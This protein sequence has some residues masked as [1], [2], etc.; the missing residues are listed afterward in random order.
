[1][2]ELELLMI[3]IFFSNGYTEN[4]SNELLIIDSVLKTN[5]WTCTPKDLTE[6]K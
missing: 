3:K 2:I 4:W 1:M 6:K 5:S